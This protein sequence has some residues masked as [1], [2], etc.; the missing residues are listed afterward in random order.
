MNVNTFAV[1]VGLI[2][3][4]V[5]MVLSLM[6]M[7]QAYKATTT[8]TKLGGVATADTKKFAKTFGKMLPAI[9]KVLRGLSKWLFAIV[10]LQFQIRLEKVR[11]SHLLSLN[12]RMLLCESFFL[13]A[14][15]E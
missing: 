15:K 10:V 7:R 11:E 4:V 9:G 6:R 8:S 14:L 5:L 1:L 12:A 13:E 3:L 2:T